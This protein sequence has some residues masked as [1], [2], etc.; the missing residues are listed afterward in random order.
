MVLLNGNFTFST[1][2]LRPTERVSAWN[3]AYGRQLSGRELEL[4]RPAADPFQ[5]EASGYALSGASLHALGAGSVVHMSVTTGGVARRTST[6][7]GDGNDDIVLHIQ[8]AGH[9][10]VS[11]LGREATVP[12]GGG[13]LTSNADPSTIVLPSTARF[14]SI[15]LSRPLITALAPRVE[16]ALVR[17]LPPNLD[18][19][20]LLTTYL[21]ALGDMREIASPSLRWAVTRHIYD[22]C[23]LAIGAARDAAECAAG[24]GLRAA[25]LQSMKADLAANLGSA[26]VSAAGLARRQGVSPRY[27]HKLFASE[28]VTLSRYKLGLCLARVHAMLV[29]V[30]HAD[31][32]ISELAYKAGFNDLSTFNREFRRHFGSTPSAVRIGSRDR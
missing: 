22:L 18:V 16:D 28:G 19:L 11:Q 13:V 6:H 30:R 10:I 15:A 27:V 23:A 14:V 4:L 2:G 7:L 5:L 24:R 31:A 29:D 1:R 32:T 3:A 21:A 12:P 25:R 26:D 20:G 17:A 8:R 9:R